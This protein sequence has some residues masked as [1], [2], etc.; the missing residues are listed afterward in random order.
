MSWANKAADHPVHSGL[1]PLVS[2]ATSYKSYTD[3]SSSADSRP[4]QRTAL[5]HRI[6]LLQ[7]CDIGCDTFLSLPTVIDYC[8]TFTVT[9][10]P[11]RQRQ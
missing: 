8:R 11:A 1:R 10:T 6:K 9:R 3:S 2:R 7:Y 4:E 5:C